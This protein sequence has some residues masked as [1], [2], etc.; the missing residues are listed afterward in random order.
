MRLLGSFGTLVPKRKQLHSTRNTACP[1]GAHGLPIR[2]Y[3]HAS[4][5][6]ARRQGSLAAN[7]KMTWR[8][9]HVARCTYMTCRLQNTAEVVSPSKT[10]VADALSK[11]ER[12]CSAQPAMAPSSTSFPAPRTEV[13]QPQPSANLPDGPQPLYPSLALL[14]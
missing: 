6:H 2:S 10:T 14:D 9:A 13:G 11:N 1:V 12:I 3:P 4:K 7:S 8:E 5:M